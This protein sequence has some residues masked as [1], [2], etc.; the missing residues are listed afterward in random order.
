MGTV[1]MENRADPERKL[2]STVFGYDWIQRRREAK[3]DLGLMLI[4]S[5]ERYKGNAIG[6]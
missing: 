3:D 5:K 4:V 1:K 6:S 2:E